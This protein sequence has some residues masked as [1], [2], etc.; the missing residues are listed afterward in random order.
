MTLFRRDIELYPVSAVVGFLLL[1][2]TNVPAV[3]DMFPRQPGIKILHY[4]FDVA[5]GD[6]SNELTVKDTVDV[7]FLAA[8]VRGIDLNL[9]SLVREPQP[10]D[11]LNSC[12]QPAP[13]PG[14]D[15]KAPAGPVPTSVGM[16]MTVS[17]VT[18]NGKP[19]TF[20]HKNNRLHISFAGD[21][22]V[23]DKVR[24]TIAYHGVPAT[25]LFIGNNKYGDR[26]W[27]T[28]NWP[29]KARNWLA[30]VDHIS[31]K[32]A[33]TITVT[34]PRAYQVIS[35]GLKTEETDLPNNL[36]RTTW[37]EKV[38]IPSW[39][40]S[41]GVGA[42]AVEYFGS[43]HGVDFS[44]WVF[45]QDRDAGF[46]A[47]DKDAKAIFEFYSDH[48][49][50]YSYEKLAHVEAA[51][52]GGA[53]ESAST[54][55]YFTGF[56][57]ESHEMGHHWFGNAVTEGDWD[58]VWLS[59][60]FATYM[61]LLWTE[62]DKG[63]DAFLTGV[64][65]TREAAM[66]YEL[67]HPDDTVVHNNLANDSDVFFNSAQIYQG[68]AMALHMLRGVL[69]DE[70]FWAG[71]RLYYSRFQNSSATTDDFR[72]AME[73]GCLNTSACKVDGHD[74]AR[75]Y[76]EW[77]NRGGILKV[78]GSW[79]YDPAAKQLE[80]SIDQTQTQG[81]YRMPIEI[82]IT[83]PAP[84]TPAPAAAARGNGGQ[85][86]PAGPETRIA[87]IL[88]DQ[89]HS[90]LSVPLEVEPTA[91]QLDPGTWVPMMQATFAKN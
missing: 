67:A 83:V 87:T 62:H 30:T 69:D 81:L 41:L 72:H 56:G 80:V 9:C 39:Q 13:R 40:F 75:F 57:A 11:R 21:S 60:G 35:N 91:V 45:P 68:G 18:S 17:D 3:A 25:G 37:D 16:G 77:L 90:T 70:A 10:A 29:N 84:A 89:Q 7:Q 36:R 27:F 63:R 28:D 74:L 22:H 82:G 1:A 52:G 20:E 44:A 31:I 51:G 65:R 53:T 15:G 48:I 59:E 6:A 86:R 26:V 24:V 2:F 58:D 5:L 73:D 85:A 8:G 54:I 12:L 88:V 34:A 14:R 71:L 55:F 38:P 42:M 32:A 78:N 66:R 50:P 49:G 19:L 79:H 23:G 61:A 33:K 4:N 64:G 43:S 47:L 76:H 46:K